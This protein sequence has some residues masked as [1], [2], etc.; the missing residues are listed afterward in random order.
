MNN[1]AAHRQADEVAADPMT[2]PKQMV[3]K[4]GRTMLNEGCRLEL[5]PEG[6]GASS[7]LPHS[8]AGRWQL[9]VKGAKRQPLRFMR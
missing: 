4:P 2:C 3:T 7:P 5:L 9:N 6:H 8:P 1:S